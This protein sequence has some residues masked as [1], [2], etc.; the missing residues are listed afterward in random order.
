MPGG[1]DKRARYTDRVTCVTKDRFGAVEQTVVGNRKS[2]ENISYRDE[3]LG[4]RLSAKDVDPYMG[5]YAHTDDFSAYLNPGP[6][7]LEELVASGLATD[8]DYRSASA[9]D[10]IFD[11][12]HPFSNVTREVQYGPAAE[13]DYRHGS[14]ASSWKTASG[15]HVSKL[16]LVE[17]APEPLWPIP[18]S[19][20]YRTWSPGNRIPVPTNDDLAS[21]GTKM[22]AKA[23]PGR[24]ES[25]LTA[26][27]GELFMG[28]P[29]APGL[30]L[31][32]ELPTQGLGSE[33][34]NIVFGILPTIS[35]AKSFGAVLKH[36]SR[37]IHQLRRDAGRPVRRRVKLPI[38]ETSQHYDDS[39]IVTGSANRSA[40]AVGGGQILFNKKVIN[41]YG[42]ST[43]QTLYGSSPV[44]TTASLDLH[45]QR[46][47]WFSG[48]FTYYVPLIPG[49]SNRVGKYVSEYDK[50]LGLQGDANV[51]WQLTPW[52]WLIDW[53]WD[54]SSQLEVISVAHDDNL[55]MNY[56]Y[57]METLERDIRA[58]LTFQWPSGYFGPGYCRSYEK[59]TVKRR[60]RANPYGFISPTSDTEWSAYRLAILAALGLSRS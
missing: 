31:L 4:T 57:A 12:G 59:L 13:Q 23:A 54:I 8:A 14:T 55:V 33:Y 25:S 6:H 35:D 49:F 39:D 15:F 38:T 21:F 18:R 37:L 53:F 17:G 43:A 3:I 28:L 44:V 47:L 36:H 1:Y 58:Q 5:F 34:L 52:S 7:F 46:R 20:S 26:A 50:L 42:G 48:S 56:G 22:I 11:N 40:Q 24:P 51:A 10:S 27:V 45:E 19:G 2:E 60:L 16:A 29:A 9:S 32:K 30:A 41:G